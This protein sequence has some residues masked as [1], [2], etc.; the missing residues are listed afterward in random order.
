VFYRQQLT[1]AAVLWAR[2][3][4]LSAPP[5]VVARGAADSFLEYS[6]GPLHGLAALRNKTAGP[7]AD[8]APDIFLASVDSLEKTRPL[9]PNSPSIVNARV[10]PN[11]KLLCYASRETGRMEIWMTPIPGPGPHVMVSID[12][13]SEPAWS[14]DGKTIF[15][16]TNSASPRMMAASIVEQPDLAV[17][18][19]DTLFP[20]IYA[21][22]VSHAAYD[23][24]PD[25]RLLMT[26][27]AAQQTITGTQ[28]YVVMHWQK[29]LERATPATVR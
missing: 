21:R 23:V 2:P 5:R 6:I 17:T 22:Q 7:R 3:W 15:Y 25:G 24:F 16:R 19:R 10:S 27:D 28:A 4:N 18:R 12:G 8:L 11:G 13:G 9:F 29:M 1:N 20:D 26:K 14:W